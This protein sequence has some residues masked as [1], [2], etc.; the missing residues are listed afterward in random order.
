[1]QTLMG[2][3][4]AMS[5]TMV[6]IP[7]LMRW[8]IP[9]RIL[10]MPGARKVH[11]IPVPRVGGIA[12][13]AGVSSALLLWGASTRALQAL[14]VGIGVLLIFGVWDDRKTLS[15]G[16]KFAGQALAVLIVMA[17]GGVRASSMTFIE[18]MPLP[19]WVALP[20]T[21]LFLIGGTNAFNLADGLDGLAGGMAMLCLCGTA[22]LAYTVGNAAIGAT[23][24]VIA[25]AVIGFLRFNTHPARVFMGD[26][27]SQMLGFSAAVLVLRL[28]QD[29][30]FPLST[31][32]PLLL[33]GMPIIDTLTVMIERLLAG[34][35]PFLADRRHIHHRLLALG[36]EHWE[37]VSILYLLQGCLFVVAWFMRY[38]PDLRVALVFAVFALLVV[39]PLHV[40]QHYGLRVRSKAAARDALPAG[41]GDA[42]E[43]TNHATTRKPGVW[44]R[45]PMQST[46]VFVLG[47]ALAA[48]AGWVLL[49][50]TRPSRDVQILALSLAA[51]LGVGLLLRWRR[52]DAAWTDKVALYSSAALAIFLSRHGLPGALRPGAFAVHPHLVEYTLYG[53]LAGA[54]MICIRSS[55]ERPF[56]LTP[57]DFLVLLVVATVPNLPDSVASTRSLGLAVAELVLL[58]YSLEALSHAAGNRWRWLSGA[59]AIFLLGLALRPGV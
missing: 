41:A 11:A 51:I 47:A 20:V 59:A 12:M 13:V 17:W 44:L 36:F 1:M 31:A 25:G 53:L 42:A 30:Q 29:T 9:L 6:L 54:M 24:V 8:A 15:A 26:G 39:V 45:T 52:D 34:R 40:A 7:V 33:L 14:W 43:G 2:F 32:L 38:D 49:T 4:L 35:S 46:G 10:D 21:F 55:G 58:F 16:P 48:Y 5:V 18:R 57:M 23:A 27:G 19:P 3:M 50:G 37:A 28:T 22:L 56:K